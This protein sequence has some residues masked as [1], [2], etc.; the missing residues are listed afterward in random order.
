MAPA[1]AARIADRVS[2][3]EDLSD[4]HAVERELL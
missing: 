4:G 3:I 1:M 2:G